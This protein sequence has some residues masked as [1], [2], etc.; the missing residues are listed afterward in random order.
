VTKKQ[1]TNPEPEQLDLPE[2]LTEQT[3]TSTEPSDLPAWLEQ[4]AGD[5]PRTPAAG[6][7]QKLSPMTV[8]LILV[9]IGLLGI[10]GLALYERNRETPTEGPAPDFAVTIWPL[11]R[12]AMAGEHLSLD[13]LKGKTIVLNFWASYCIPCQQ[14]APMFER[15]WNEY[16]GRGVVFLGVNTEDPDSVAFDYIEEY[17]LTY[18]HA[19]DQGGRMEEAYRTTG[20]PETF[21]INGDGEIT[22][23]FISTPR[24]SDLRSEIEQALGE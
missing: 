21:I 22:R 18:P 6:V 24:E 7:Q 14:E 10:I 4:A 16:K 8:V 5:A 11:D 3:D 20:I 1:L 15:L 12:L 2:W 17:N 19:P 9:A 13:S 23:H